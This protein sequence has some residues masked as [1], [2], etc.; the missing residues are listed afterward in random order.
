[1][2]I[3][4]LFIS[5]SIEDLK[6]NLYQNFQLIL[7]MYF[8]EMFCEQGYPIGQCIVYL[9]KWTVKKKTENA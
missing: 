3:I 7:R 4:Y 8:P 2:Y 6:F 1:M 5:K 9:L